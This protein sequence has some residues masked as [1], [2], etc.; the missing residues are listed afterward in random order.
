MGAS[1]FDADPEVHPDDLDVDS[2]TSTVGDQTRDRRKPNRGRGTRTIHS[3]GSV[4]RPLADVIIAYKLP[5]TGLILAIIVGLVAGPVAMLLGAVPSL[6]WST[7]YYASLGAMVTALPSYFVWRR[8][9]SVTGV[10]ILDMDPVT[11]DHRHLRVGH[12]AFSKMKLLTPWGKEADTTDLQRCTING[13]AGYELMD[14][15]VPEGRDYPVAFVTWLGDPA[16][17]EGPAQP[18]A[19]G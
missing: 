17:K 9:S 10:E 5:L 1:E 14:L 3:R 8:V 7:V 15:R 12:E 6:A 11:G 16:R 13:R 19:R 4:L 2:A 18:P